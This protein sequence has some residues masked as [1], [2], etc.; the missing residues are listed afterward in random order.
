M[1]RAIL[2]IFFGFHVVKLADA[3]DSQAF[4]RE[5]TVYS[6]YLGEM[7]GKV[8][9]SIVDD[10]HVITEK[11][12]FVFY[13]GGAETPAIRFHKP[14]ERFKWRPWLAFIAMLAIL[15]FSLFSD[16]LELTKSRN[17]KSSKSSS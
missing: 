5:A 1:I 10:L 2:I 17:T 13:K 15:C 8:Y 11:G 9:Y 16:Y 14:D 3:W 6:N 7:E 4:P 12:E